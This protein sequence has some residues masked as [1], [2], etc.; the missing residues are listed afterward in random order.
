MNDILRFKYEK[1]V[2]QVFPANELVKNWLF[3]EG[4]EDEAILANSLA[5]V[6]EKNSLS[7]NDLHHLFPYVLRMLKSEINWS[8]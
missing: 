2:K 8:K 1:G 4:E 6:A 5:K 7:A 3:K